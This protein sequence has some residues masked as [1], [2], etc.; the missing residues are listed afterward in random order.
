MTHPK[1]SSIPRR[2]L[3]Q[4]KVSALFLPVV[5]FAGSLAGNWWA[6]K[7]RQTEQHEKGPLHGRI[8]ESSD[9]LDR[10]TS[11][12]DRK[13]RPIKKKQFIEPFEIPNLSGFSVAE[14]VPGQTVSDH[15][16]DS[17]HE[18]FY[19]LSG[20]GLFTIDGKESKV[21]R[22]YMIHLSPKEKHQIVA[23]ESPDGSPLTMAYFGVTV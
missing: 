12:I 5:F 1:S 23:Q 11:H 3:L 2:S 8:V 13:G 6:N 16:H 21:S 18:V 10:D 4:G 7:S 22:G 19:I 17:M 20:T 9:L 15:K 14:L